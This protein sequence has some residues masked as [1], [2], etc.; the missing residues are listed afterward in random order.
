MK[1]I[2]AYIRVSTEGQHETGLGEDAQRR[3]LTE[4]ATQHNLRIVAEYA[5]TAS[6]AAPLTKRPGLNAAINDAR[7]RKCQVVVAKL[8]RLSRSVHFISGL[9]AENVPFIVTQFGLNV[10]PFMLHI[11]AAVAQQERL[12]ISQRTKAALAGRVMSGKSLRKLTLE[13]EKAIYEANE[14]GVSPA[15]LAL[16][17]G[18]SRQSTYEAIARYRKVRLG[19]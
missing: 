7:K 9:M 6:G 18:I 14:R 3:A 10:D 4:F 2:V 5:D 13:T 17:Y 8:D 1:D 12:M 19:Q 15:K 11:Y 16:E